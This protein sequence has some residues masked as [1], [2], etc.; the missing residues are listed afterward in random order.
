MSLTA[1]KCPVCARGFVL[2]GRGRCRCGADLVVLR[3]LRFGYTF[4]PDPETW[5]M[6]TDGSWS[7]W[8]DAKN[9]LDDASGE[10]V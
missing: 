8:R 9:L 4:S 1:I 7:Q 10:R 2:N 5:I 6:A 3:A